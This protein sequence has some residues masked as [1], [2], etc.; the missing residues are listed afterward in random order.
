M[1][2][3]GTSGRGGLGRVNELR[4]KGRWRRDERTQK[5]VSS[6]GIG[7]EERLPH[8]VDVVKLDL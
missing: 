7:V 1:E 8:C 4:R 3:S 2:A 5:E 6:R